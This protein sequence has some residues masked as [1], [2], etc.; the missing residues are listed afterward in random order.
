MAVKF[1][2]ETVAYKSLQNWNLIPK[3]IIN[4]PTIE[5]FKSEIKRGKVKHASVGFAKQIC[6]TLVL[7]KHDHHFLQPIFLFKM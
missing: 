1:N 3:N 6:K 7:S 2:I 4:A 5:L